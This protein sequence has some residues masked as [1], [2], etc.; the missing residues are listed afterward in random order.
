MVEPALAF[1]VLVVADC[2]VNVTAQKAVI[3]TVERTVLN[4]LL[5][6][7]LEIMSVL[8]LNALR[9]AAQKWEN[10]NGLNTE[11]TEQIQNRGT[12]R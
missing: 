12:R 2:A 1:E 9:V 7:K 6:A 8:K 3:N 10:S 5:F 4:H 11:Q